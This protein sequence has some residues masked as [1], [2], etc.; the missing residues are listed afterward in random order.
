V[1]YN[2]RGYRDQWWA[3]VQRDSGVRLGRVVTWVQQ[4]TAPDD[5]LSV[6]DDPAVYLYTGRRTVPATGSSASEHVRPAP[7]GS[8][9]ADVREILERYQ[10]RFYIVSWQNALRA[11]DSLARLR[12]GVLRPVDRIASATVYVTQQR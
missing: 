1:T 12:P 10:P 11:A 6:E 9:I 8:V 5:V 3:A 2:F 7:P 4:N